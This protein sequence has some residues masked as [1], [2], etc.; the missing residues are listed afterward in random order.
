MNLREFLNKS[1]DIKELTDRILLLDRSIMEL[2]QNGYYVN[3]SLSEIEIIN[4]EI[5]LDSFKNRIDRIDSGYDSNGKDKNIYEM[6]VIGICAYNKVDAPITSNLI[7]Y[8]SD[9]IDQIISYKHIP[10]K[11][12]EYYRAVLKD[13]K[14]DYLNNYLDKM[15][16]GG[17][18]NNNSKSRSY[19]KSTAIGR[20]FAEQ[21][22][23]YVNVLMVPSIIFM[24]YILVMVTL[25]LIKIFG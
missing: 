7:K 5:T 6:A 24:I 18:E 2:H 14:M 10:V 16:K 19:T 22:S 3:G 12:G 21:E 17:K 11:V 23:A 4:N 13:L 15:D 8:V 1:A 25:L 20:A 9:N